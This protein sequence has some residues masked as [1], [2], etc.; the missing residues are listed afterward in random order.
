MSDGA[1]PT[2]NDP[3]EPE[4]GNDSVITLPGGQSGFPLVPPNGG[5]DP[6]VTFPGDPHIT[7]PNVGNAP[8]S[9]TSVPFNRSPL[10]LEQPH[11]GND[12]VVT[13]PGG[14]Q[15][16]FPNSPPAEPEPPTSAKDVSTSTNP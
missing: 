16:T 8:L 11:A 5:N 1:P 14:P 15:I 13:I 10:Q 3:V 7:F 9:L 6:V 12:P 4:A 2:Q